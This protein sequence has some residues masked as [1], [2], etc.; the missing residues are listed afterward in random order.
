MAPLLR[1]SDLQTHYT[2]FG[3]ARV[4][5]AVDGISFT[6]REG[7]TIG[8]V[9]ESGCGKT[10]TSK[11]ILLQETPSA[12][13][14][15]FDGEDISTLR[16]DELMRYRR[17]VQVVF[18]NPHS[19]LSPRMRAGDII[20][21]PLEIHTKL[22]RQELAERVA[23]VLELVGLEPGAVGAL[24]AGGDGRLGGLARLRRQQ[25]GASRRGTLRRV[26]ARRRNTQIAPSAAVQGLEHSSGQAWAYRGD[27]R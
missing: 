5:K 19:S 27:A 12:R 15:C 20:A 25:A 1:V 18:Q 8:L 7:E 17:E 13:T 16:D 3:G 14:I 26:V 10:T 24:A 22:S 23:E 21:E 9:G 11:L 2:S 6:L 4:V